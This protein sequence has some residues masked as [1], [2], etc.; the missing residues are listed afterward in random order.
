MACTDPITHTSATQSTDIA[1]IHALRFAVIFSMT[2]GLRNSTYR[3]RRFY[4][5][6]VIEG[7]YASLE[8]T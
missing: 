4:R 8:A 3:F 1:L 5:E 6:M 2:S 7:N